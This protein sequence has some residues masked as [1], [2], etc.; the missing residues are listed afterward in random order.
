MANPYIDMTGQ[1]FGKLVVVEKVSNPHRTSADDTAAQWLCHCD[2][3]KDKVIRGDVLR[4]GK[5]MSCGCSRIKH[6]EEFPRCKFNM[7]VDCWDDFSYCKKC[8]WNPEVA[9]ARLLELKNRRMQSG[10]PL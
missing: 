7:G 10:E 5:A 3:G 6:T 4:K 1:R 9:T 8:G 2:C